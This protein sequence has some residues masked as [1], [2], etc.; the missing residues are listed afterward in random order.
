MSGDLITKG[1]QILLFTHTRKNVEIGVKLLQNQNPEQAQHIFA[2]RSG[3][4]PSERRKIE[5]LLKTGKARAVVAT[6]A[7]ELGVDIGGMEAVIISGYPGSIAS[8][9]QQAGR[10]GRKKQDSL[11]VLVASSN[12]LDQYILKNPQFI[13]EN[14][15]EMALINPNNP[16][17]L[18]QHIRCAVFELPFGKTIPLE[19]S[20]GIQFTLICRC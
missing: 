9:H 12:P 3:Y 4:L 14:P 11:A 15:P 2:Y 1:V 17:I 10:A 5:E 8:T 18:L 6:N 16:L 13:F 19:N 20:P 7:L